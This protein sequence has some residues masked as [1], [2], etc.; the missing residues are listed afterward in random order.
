MIIAS[1]IPLLFL[2]VAKNLCCLWH[3]SFF[4]YFL[5]FS[6]FSQFLFVLFLYYNMSLLSSMSS[7]IL[8]IQHSLDLPLGF[9]IAIILVLMALIIRPNLILVL[10]ICVIIICGSFSSPLVRR[11]V[12]SVNHKLL[13]C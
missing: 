9:I 7:F 4:S 6:S 11:P 1:N 5:F 12:P 10:S 13:C 3:S 2:S 8:S